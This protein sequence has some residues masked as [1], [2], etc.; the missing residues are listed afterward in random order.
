MK[1]SKKAELWFWVTCPYEVKGQ[2]GTSQKEAAIVSSKNLYSD[3]RVWWVLAQVKAALGGFAHSCHLFREVASTKGSSP[4]MCLTAC[5]QQLCNTERDSLCELC[6]LLQTS[7][8]ILSSIVGLTVWCKKRHKNEHLRFRLPFLT[9]TWAT[10]L[11]LWEKVKSTVFVAFHF[12]VLFL[13]IQLEVT[14]DF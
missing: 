6:V 12:A 1:K 9:C 4:A 2:S 14:E 11:S 8:W 13:W 10:L 7:L 3:K 5:I